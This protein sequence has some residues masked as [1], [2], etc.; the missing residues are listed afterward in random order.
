LLNEIKMKK[1]LIIS[2][3]PIKKPRHGGQ[4]R[5][6]KILDFYRS[7]GFDVN[8]ISFYEGGAY[9][10]DVV[11]VG[12]VSVNMISVKEYFNLSVDFNIFNDYLT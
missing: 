4:I 11:D 8:N 1:A 5:L 3:Y 9:S 6:R 12:D 2:T 10:D 7:L